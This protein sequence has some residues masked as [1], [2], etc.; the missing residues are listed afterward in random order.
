MSRRGFTLIEL[1]VVVAIIAILI[2]ILAPVLSASRKSARS[3]ACLSQLREIGVAT[4]DYTMNNDDYFPRSSHS[5]MA[6]GC[7]PWGY[8]LSPY[9]GYGM[10]NGPGGEW[11]KLFNGLYRCR[12]DRRN[13]HW[14]Y[15]KS[16][17]FELTSGETGEL[18]GVAEGP[19][20]TKTSCVTRVSTTIIFGEVASG[21]MED[22]V[23]AHF[24]Y[25]GATPEVDGNR[26]GATS[27]YGFVDGHAESRRFES[28]FDLTARTDLWNPGV[29]IAFP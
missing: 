3:T 14:S 5:A 15:G 21:S 23:M 17:W 12:E 13:D 2:A 24:W 28:T 7:L 29:A 27:N 18:E 19:T 6:Y 20:F 4:T 1:L 8:A 22:H 16:V 11:E 25:L 10:Y 9:L 26:H